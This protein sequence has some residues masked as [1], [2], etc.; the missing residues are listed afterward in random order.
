MTCCPA[1][2]WGFPFLTRMPAR[3]ISTPVRCFTQV[4]LAD[5]INRATPKTQSALLEAMEEQQ[6]TIEG[7]DPCP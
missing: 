2:F 4:L 3:F 1:I 7:E 6:V 5:E